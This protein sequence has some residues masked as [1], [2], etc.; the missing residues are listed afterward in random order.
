MNEFSLSGTER[1]Q[2]ERKA[3]HGKAHFLP[4]GQPPF[5]IRLLDMSEGGLRIACSVNPQLMSVSVIRMSV[6]NADR[7]AASVVEVPVQILNSIYARTEDGFRVGLRFLDMP[8]AA[9]EVIAAFL[10]N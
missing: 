5:Q 4:P 6:P 10:A 7:T 1:R 8:S 2:H 3:L 9:K